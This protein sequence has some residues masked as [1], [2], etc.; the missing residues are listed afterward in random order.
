MNTTLWQCVECRRVF[1]AIAINP[2]CPDCDNHDENPDVIKIC[3]IHGIQ[4]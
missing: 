1:T 3:N 4:N 2:V